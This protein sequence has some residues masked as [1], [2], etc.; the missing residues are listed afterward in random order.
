MSI[1]P[2][3]W[4]HAMPDTMVKE[5]L[6]LDL[7]PCPFCGNPYPALWVGPNP[8]VTCGNCGADGPCD[9]AKGDIVVNQRNAI[10]RWNQRVPTT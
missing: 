7:L 8:H 3:N 5:R 2:I 6:G 1:A 4:A 9:I 10:F